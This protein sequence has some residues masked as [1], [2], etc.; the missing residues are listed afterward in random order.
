MKN[1]KQK[2]FKV[3]GTVNNTILKVEETL[4]GI[5][6]LALVAAIFIEV[7]CRYVF[8]ISTAWSE[9]LARYLFII[10]TFVGSSYAYYTHDHIE[11]DILNQVV[12]SS[13]LKESTKARLTKGIGIMGNVSTMIFLVIFNTIFWGYLA[14]IFDMGLLSPTMHIPMALIYSFV[15]IGGALSIIH[16]LY[17]L[18]CDL[19]LNEQPEEA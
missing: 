17:I 12:R 15:Y 7:I 6:T 18:L 9:E 10:L 3:L 1:T 5:I 14:K 19:F 11:I 2:I 13:K 16:G 4:L 8:F